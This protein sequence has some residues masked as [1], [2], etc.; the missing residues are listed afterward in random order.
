[1]VGKKECTQCNKA[2]A[3]L[4]ETVVEFSH[5][6]GQQAIYMWTSKEIWCVNIC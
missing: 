1:M 5:D 4:T 6:L 2:S 3:K